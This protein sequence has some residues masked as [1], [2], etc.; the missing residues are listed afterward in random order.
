[1]TQYQITNLVIVES[2][3]FFLTSKLI[4]ALALNPECAD[5]VLYVGAIVGGVVAI[6][7]AASSPLLAPLMVATLEVVKVAAAIQFVA[8]TLAIGVEMVGA[9]GCLAAVKFEII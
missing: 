8:S 4:K 2:V 5:F 6:G 1:M 9:M 7:L 3:N